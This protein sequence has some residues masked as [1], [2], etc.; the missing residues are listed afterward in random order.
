MDWMFRRWQTGRITL[1]HLPNWQLAVWLLASAVM[2]LGHPQGWVC[3]VLVVLASVALA[4][5]G[6]TR[7]CVGGIPSVASWVSQ[8]SP[9]SLFPW[10][11]SADNL[12]RRMRIGLAFPPGPCFG[13]PPRNQHSANGYVTA[14]TFVTSRLTLRTPARAWFVRFARKS[15]AE[16]LGGRVCDLLVRAD[17]LNDPRS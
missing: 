3:V 14:A 17:V 6:A 1:T 11:D 15:A 7:Y 2:W 5:W 10:S 12:S 4:L 9:G 16:R 8:C 13:K